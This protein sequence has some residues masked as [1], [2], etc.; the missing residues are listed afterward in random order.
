V[1][2]VAVEAEG[3]FSRGFTPDPTGLLALDPVRGQPLNPCIG[4]SASRSIQ[5]GNFLGEGIW[6]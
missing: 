5:K 4:S 2:V 3:E 6:G 1:A